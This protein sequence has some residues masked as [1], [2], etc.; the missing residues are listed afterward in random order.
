[1][2]YLDQTGLNTLVS[3][4]K[5]YVGTQI[6]PVKTSA[7]N[8]Q[9]AAD[10]I[11]NRFTTFAGSTTKML[12]SDNT[13]AGAVEF[14]GSETAADILQTSMGASS[15]TEGCSV[16]YSTKFNTFVLKKDNAYYNNWLDADQFG[17]TD[18]NGKGRFPYKTKI[19]FCNK[20]CYYWNGTAL[21]KA[22]D[23][24]DSSIDDVYETIDS[25]YDSNSCKIISSALP[26]Y[27]DDIVEYDGEQT[28]EVTVINSV[29]QPGSNDKILYYTKT[30]RF[31]KKIGDAY[32]ANWNEADNYGTV[33]S[34]GVIPTQSKIYVWNNVMQY[35]NGTKLTNLVS[36]DGEFI[37]NIKNASDNALNFVTGLQSNTGC[38]VFDSIQTG[39]YAEASPMKETDGKIYFVKKTIIDLNKP[40][41]CFCVKT[42][43]GAYYSGG[44]AGIY[45]T[46]GSLGTV[47][48][49]GKIFVSKDGTLYMSNDA[50]TNIQSV[51]L[52]N[53]SINALFK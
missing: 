10:D 40:V 19:Y 2:K 35:W 47:P 39:S 52:D 5:T 38:L 7:E 14:A 45:N 48:A 51:I 3:N 27:I 8:A 22:T 29:G 53:D 18:I 17:T 44:A 36:E 30:N 31:I 4:I 25:F 41:G 43:D 13:I 32:Y 12:K 28:T 16:I 21:I 34:T 1:M 9:K 15:T 23:S 49:K 20:S 46:E 24:V 37:T 11:N 6:S 50:Q 33:T 42:V 26:S